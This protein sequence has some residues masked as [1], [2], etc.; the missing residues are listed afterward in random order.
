MAQSPTDPSPRPV[1]RRFAPLAILIA[2]LALFLALGGHRYVS[3][4]HLKQH[5]DA[6]KGWADSW[7]FAAVLAFIVGYAVMVAFSIPG[8]ALGTLL[9]GFLFGVAG[10]TA[11]AVVG[12]TLGA[13]AVYLAARTA[14]GDL[15]RRRAGPALRRMEEGFRRDAFSYLLGLRLIPVFPFWLVNIVPAFA[16]VPLR[17]FVLATLIGIVPGTLVYAWIGAGLDD[18]LRQGRTPDL[19]M[20]LEPKFLIPILAL[21]I[22]ALAPVVLRRRNRSPSRS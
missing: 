12:A 17:T 3:F 9:G 19:G 22:L 21:A 13:A 16:A 15:L 7:G 2:G 1:W 4:D 11:A 14:I 18:L 6:L 20:I 10:G 5:R 8:G